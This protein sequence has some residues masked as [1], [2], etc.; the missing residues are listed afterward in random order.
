[1]ASVKLVHSADDPVRLSFPDLFEAR[2]YEGQGPH[3]YSA[4]FLVKPNGENAKRIKAAMLEAATELWPK[5]APAKLKSYE[6]N[7]NRCCF[8]SGDLKEYDGYAGMMALSSHR[9]QDA[10]RPLV[11]DGQKNPLSPQDGKPYAGC[12]VNAFV[13]IYCQDGQ[14]HG[15]RC[16]L[17]GVQF[18]ADGDSFSGSRVASTDDFDTIDD[19]GGGDT[20]GLA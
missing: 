20:D 11:I 4:T 17:R 10:G 16:G 12:Y 7:S 6:G 14:N 5:A 18:A 9:K 13:D 15:V 2:Q 19:T 8:T 3:R 1:M